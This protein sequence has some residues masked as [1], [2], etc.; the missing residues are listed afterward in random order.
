MNYTNSQKYIK[1]YFNF[2]IILL[3]WLVLWLLMPMGV[4]PGGGWSSGG[5]DVFVVAAV[6]LELNADST[7][8]W[9][10]M[11]LLMKSLVQQCSQTQACRCQA[12]AHPELPEPAAWGDK[13]TP[14]SCRK[15]TSSSESRASLGPRGFMVPAICSS[16]SKP[17]GRSK[18]AVKP[19]PKSCFI[20]RVVGATDLATCLRG[21]SL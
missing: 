13:P 7:V 1:Y 4:W 2:L 6:V 3:W 16:S 12:F 19:T 11:A 14:R 17:Q 8:V 10:Y 20:G 15:R 5:F 21:W 9:F 18:L